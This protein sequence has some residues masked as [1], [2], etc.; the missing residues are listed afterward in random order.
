MHPNEQPPSTTDW[1]DLTTTATPVRVGIWVL[2]A[3]SVVAVGVAHRANPVLAVL[4]IAVVLAYGLL[5]IIDAAEQRLPNRITLPLAGATFVAVFI[6]GIVRSDIGA[7][8]GAIG[9]GFAFAIVLFVMRFGMGDVKMAL[10]VGAIAGWLGRDAVLATML[11]GAVAGAVV[12]LVLIAIYRRRT[13]S[14][15]YGPFLAIGSVVGMVAAG[16]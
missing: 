7:G 8:L 3:V 10:T 4:L 1:L 16:G 5:S 13:I 2:T 6:G 11:A 14:F 15:S 9:V 12:A